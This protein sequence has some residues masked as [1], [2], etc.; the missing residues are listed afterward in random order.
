MPPAAAT[1]ARPLTA[2][3]QATLDSLLARASSGVG[4]A[5]RIGEA[6][7]ALIALSV[8]RRGDK[9]RATDLVMP[10]ETVYLTEEEARQFERHGFRDGRK[11]A[12][13]RKLSGPDGSR[14]SRC[15]GCCPATSPAACSAPRP[16]RPA[17]TRP[18]PTR[19]A[20]AVIQVLEDGRAPG[21]RGRH[22]RAAV[23]DGRPPPRARTGRP[24]PTAHPR[25]HPGARRELTCG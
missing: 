23:G 18:A 21:G 22:D 12:V 2:E 17:P 3:E 13:V 20:P 16:R 14:V 10:G 5:A 25:P 8:P 6:Y 19:K 9:D 1:D 4:P 7:E 24:R 15:R 11:M